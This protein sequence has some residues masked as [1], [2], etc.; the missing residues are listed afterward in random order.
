[1]VVARAVSFPENFSAAL[2]ELLLGVCEE[3]QLTTP[4]HDLAVERYGVLNR[5]LEST[6]SPFRYF[7]PEIY[8]QGS[9]ALGTTVKPVQ[10]PHDLDFVLQLSR[11]HHGVEPMALIRS[12]YDFLRQQPTY[13]AMTSMKNRCVR[14]EYA[15][16][17][18]MD[19]LPACDNYTATGTCIKVPDRKAKDWADSNPLGYIEWFKQRSRMLQIDRVLDRAAPVPEQQAVEDKETLQLVVQL[20]KRW[21]DRHYVKNQELAPISIV[22][23]TLAAHVYRGERS[24]SQA[25]TSV[26]GGIVVLIDDSRR[27][28]Q[29]YLR[30]L[31]PSNPAEDLSER[32][33]SDPD[34]YTA[35]ERGIRDFHAQWSQLI[36]RGGNVYADLEI[37]FGEPVTTVLK[38]RAK[39]V[40]GLREAGRLGVMRSGAIA[41]TGAAAVS[42]RPNTFYGEK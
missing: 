15:D 4:R 30:V 10:G 37:L 39:G 12:L 24:V 25:L 35:F 34:S 8:P 21:R 13:H 42:A 5:L 33:A 1:M 7:Q 2:D 40:Q 22:L 3:L 23:T 18:Y 28:G 41:S 32:W 17:F 14:V 36:E 27:L 26:L 6:E 19:I 16:E 31:N 9:M 20:L 29:K 38:K 11:D